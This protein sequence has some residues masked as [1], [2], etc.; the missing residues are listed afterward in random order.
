MT[1]PLGPYHPTLPE[2]IALRLA[3]R[4]E[5]VTGV[6]THVGYLRRGIEDLATRRDLEGA[7]DVIEH[8]C[9]TC[10]TGY[11]LAACMALEKAAGVT[12]PPLAQALRTI[13]AELERAL[14]R[15]WTLQQVARIGEFGALLTATLEAREILF[16]AATQATGR[17]LFWG[18]A[19]P[20]GV[21]AVEDPQALEDALDEMAPRVD[22]IERF[23][24]PQGLVGRSL[25]R[26]GTIDEE[27]ATATGLTGIMLRATGVDDDLR[28]ANPYA[29]Y[30]DVAEHLT[31]DPAGYSGDVTSRLRMAALDLRASLSIIQALLAELPSGQDRASFPDSLSDGEAQSAIEAARGRGSINLRIGN[32]QERQANTTASGW[33]TQLTLQTPGAVNVGIIPIVCNGQQL[34][35]IPLILASL[36]LCIACIDL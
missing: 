18:I 29:A 30:A 10:G 20:G 2:P 8:A 4:G 16:E 33:L 14:A 23:V 11:R 32:G 36:D 34:S 21:R 7:L 5:K 28:V 6:D 12:P 15:L 22:E 35:D 31:W 3:L 25:A 26:M 27:M 24:G 1:F 9:G 13:F 19:I 17:R